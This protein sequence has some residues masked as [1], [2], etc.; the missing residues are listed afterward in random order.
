MKVRVKKLGKDDAKWW[1]NV[2]YE[3]EVL[4]GP[5]PSRTHKSEFTI[6]VNDDH[7]RVHLYERG[8][9]A[10]GGPGSEWEFVEQDNCDDAY[11]RAMGVL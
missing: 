4:E 5:Y 8:S 3:Y 9:N 10:L 7:P 1:V 11:D 2:H 6:F